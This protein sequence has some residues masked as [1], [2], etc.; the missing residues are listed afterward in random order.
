MD[1]HD[2]PEFSRRISLK[3]IGEI[4]YSIVIKATSDECYQLAK[5]L[6]LKDIYSLTADI[7]LT[8]SNGGKTI[9]LKGIFKA[10][11]T[12]TCVA[13]LDS[14]SKNIEGKF[15]LLYES[16]SKVLKEMENTIEFNNNFEKQ[17][18]IEPLT[19]D[20]IDV[21]EAISEQL[22]LKI[23]QFPRKSGV[24]FIDFSTET[25]K[26]K[27]TSDLAREKHSGELGLFS[28]LKNL[29]IN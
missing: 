14:I 16:N 17:D 26:S 20:S 8:P 6:D 2:Q 7:S 15:N 27:V 24:S 25:R 10:N 11:I 19:E 21:G 13:T 3:S 4:E 23:D 22:A 29:K 9:I 1:K 18:F 28:K 5:R 12:Q